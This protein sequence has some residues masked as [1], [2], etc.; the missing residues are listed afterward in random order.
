MLRLLSFVILSWLSVNA[1]AQTPQA[2]D[3]SKTA[4]KIEQRGQALIDNY[5]TLRASRTVLG[6]SKLYFDVYEGEGM[7]TAVASINASQNKNTEA[8]FSQLIGLAGNKV[9]PQQLQIAFNTLKQQL[10]T[11]LNI[12]KP[13]TV[14]SFWGTLF[15]AF[16]LLVREGFEAL[17]IVTALLAYLARAGAKDK[18]YAV[19][20]GVIAALAASAVTAV[21]FTTLLKN[22]GANREALEGGTMLVAAAVLLYVSYWLFANSKKRQSA[23]KNNVTR[24][25]TSG[26]LWALG[27]AAF[28]AVYR[29][30]AETILFYQALAIGKS[31]QTFALILGISAATVVL[32]ALYWIMRR[33]TVKIPFSLFFGVTAIFL[34]YMAFSFVGD[35][36]MELQEARL[37]GISPIMNMPNI[38]WLG[39]HPTWQTVG[40]QL[41]F[42]IPTALGLIIWQ[43]KRTLS[44]A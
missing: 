39:I 33:A 19:Y 21:I 29:E 17:L 23:L 40:A 44:A 34:Y 27:L 8:A 42:L 10:K 2:P 14:K 41:A 20:T 18:S 30:G 24:A 37:V 5:Q 6:F 36:I 7:E 13:G 43:R 12:I 11:D 4:A 3:Y 22:S 31:G 9:P 16:M 1:W 15:E 38:N 32:A 35:G 28:L 26:S 25:L